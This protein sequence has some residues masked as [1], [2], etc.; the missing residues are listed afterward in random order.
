[1]RHLG[2]GAGLADPQRAAS[3]RFLAIDRET[4]AVRLRHEV[5]IGED[6]LL[7]FV[8]NLSAR[9][10]QSGRSTCSQGFWRRAKR[11]I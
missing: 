3:E 1:M 11:R 7:G 8:G 4:E 10:D 9:S 2:Y 5:G 6:V